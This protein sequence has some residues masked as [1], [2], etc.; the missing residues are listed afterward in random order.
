[1][2]I[3]IAEDD[4][5]TSLMLQ[6]ILNKW[7]F[8]TVSAINGEKAWEILKKRDSPQ[9]AL[10][11]WEMPGIDGVEV[12]LRTKK[13]ET[14]VSTYIIMLTVRDS[15][16]DIVQGLEA[17]ADDYITKPFD[18]NELRAR[19]NVAKR[20]VNTHLSLSKK[21]KELKLALNHVKKLQGI[22]PICMYCHKIRNDTQAWDRLEIYIRNHSDAEFS[23]S[24]CPDCAKKHYPDIDFEDS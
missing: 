18:E 14:L 11:D 22:I 17:G 4:L 16:N 23:H 9:I 3:L 2:K 1:M 12:C 24:I 13:L 21:I 5:T 8:N 10:L 6:S 19:I 15:K 20:M 7:G